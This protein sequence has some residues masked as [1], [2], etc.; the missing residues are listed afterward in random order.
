MKFE[1]YGPYEIP[2]IK[3]RK[4][5][6]ITKDSM[7]L[8]QEQI[9]NSELVNG[10]GCYVFALRAARGYKPWYVGQSARMKLLP[11]AMN[12]N[13]REKYNRIIGDH[14]GTPVLFL[15]PMLTTGGK[16][17]KPTTNKAGEL[18]AVTFLE[19]WL[20]ASALQKNAKLVNQQN[21]FFLKNLHVVGLF[22][23]KVG[24]GHTASRELKR[25]IF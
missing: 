4:A 10:C 18:K 13:N 6:L 3:Y 9:N 7:P 1:I 20:I 2:R 23:P 21:T 5:K 16:F 11:E 24:E 8:L 19:E 25:A 17:K 15:I 12:P 22:N 14:A